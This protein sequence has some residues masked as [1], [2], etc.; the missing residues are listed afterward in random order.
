MSFIA[1]PPSA[2][3]PGEPPRKPIVIGLVNNMP[4]AALRT[5]ERQVCDLI[6]RAAAASGIAVSFRLFSLPE[7]PRSD[8]GRDH[9][10]RFHEPIATLR[11]GDV[12]GLIVTGTEPR[13]PSLEVEPYWP[14]LADLVDWAVHH[15]VS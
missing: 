12:V 13:A 8:I 14:P 9:C 3:Q 6:T 2:R 4:D 5:T 1:R 11:E 15:T 7:V 10:R